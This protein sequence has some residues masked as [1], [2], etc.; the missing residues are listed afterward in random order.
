MSTLVDQ[1]P[2]HSPGTFFCAVHD[3]A[4]IAGAI[5]GT[6]GEHCAGLFT[7]IGTVSSSS[8]CY[9]RRPLERFHINVE[10]GFLLVAL[11]RV[12]LAHADHLSKNLDVEAIALGFRIDL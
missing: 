7:D 4:S 8:L 5:C 11:L 12:L 1:R 3:F 9:R 10:E 2:G 6:I